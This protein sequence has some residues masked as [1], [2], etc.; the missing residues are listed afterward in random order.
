[1]KLKLYA[2]PFSSYCQKALIALYENSTPFEF[3]LLAHDDP[4][5]MAEFA[6]LWPI[7]RFPV[8]VDGERTVT[9]ASIIIEYLGLHYPGPV[10]LVPADA[11]A[12]LDV[13]SM[14]R[15]FDNYISTPQQ[16]IVFDSLR[17]E[18]ERDARGVTEARAMLDTAY[19]W[20][21]K[22]MA[23]RE[24]AAGDTFSLADCAAAPALFYAD[25]SHAIDPAFAH[26]RAYR[27]RLLARPSFARA[28]DEAR[29]YR[30]L[31]PL[32]APDRD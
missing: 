27:E 30:P 28:V 21:D 8:L 22:T 10:A 17:S 4:Q 5:I 24:W 3:R 14:D 13:R 26:V 29:P 12:A 11:R 19:A 7:R 2:H 1:M 18:A 25:W 9:E 31:F 6:E 23:A 15:F 20:L 32:G 16:K